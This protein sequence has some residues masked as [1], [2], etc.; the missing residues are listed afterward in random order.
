MSSI[1]EQPQS[2]PILKG[3]ITQ[4]IRAY[5]ES[6]KSAENI[7]KVGTL[8]LLYEVSVATSKGAKSQLS[9]GI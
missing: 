7:P 9:H 5:E 1:T 6:Q 8:G 2:D 4:L 3:K